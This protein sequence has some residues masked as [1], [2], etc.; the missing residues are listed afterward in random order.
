[1]SNKNCCLIKTLSGSKII[2]YGIEEDLTNKVQSNKNLC[3]INIDEVKYKPENFI[4]NILEKDDLDISEDI[5]W[6][7]EPIGTLV[8]N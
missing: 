5:L 8:H 3:D 7:G 6:E 1:M 2:K 4:I